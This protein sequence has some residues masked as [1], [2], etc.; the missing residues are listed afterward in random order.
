M[1][2]QRTLRQAVVTASL[3]VAFLCQGT[4]ALAGVTGN[5]Q[6]TVKDAS[7]AP[8]AGVQVQVV[9]PSESRSAT[10]DAG[11]HFIVLSLNPDTYTINLTRAGYQPTSQPGV[12]IFADQTQS[13]ALTMVKSLKTIARVTSQAGT[14]LVKSGVGA[15]LYSINAAQASAAAALGG[16]G[17]LNNAYSAMASVPGVQTSQGGIAW[18]FNGAYVRG[19][20]Y[21]YT[22]FEYDGIPI[23]RSFDNYNAST[24]SNL[25]LQELQVY[26]G[27]GPASITSSGTSGFINQVIKSGTFPGFATVN[28]GIGAPTFYHQ[29]QVEFGG[30]TPDRT[31]SYYVGLSGYNQQLRFFDSTNGAGYGVPGGIFSGNTGGFLIGYGALSNQILVTSPT[32]IEGIETG[33]GDKGMCPLVGQAFSAPSQGCWQYYSG[34]GGNPFQIA[35]RENVINLHLGVPKHNGLRDDVQLLW[36]GSAL[37]NYFDESP[38]DLGTSVNQFSYSAYGTH[39]AAP[40]C[41]PENIAPGLTVNGCHSPTGAAGQII[42]LAGLGSYFTCTAAGGP[43]CGP[44]YAGYAD[45]VAYNTPFGTPIATSPGNIKTPGVYMAPD[46]PSHDFQGPLPLFDNSLTTIRNDTGITKVQYTY[47]LSQSAYLRAYGY[48]FYSDWMQ[49]NPIYGATGQGVPTSGAAAQYD[50]FTHTSGGSL[51]FQDQLNDQNLISLDG[52]YST[53][54]VI[55][56]NNSA[57]FGPDSPIGYM[58]Q[59]NGTYTCYGEN[60]KGTKFGVPVP[61]LSSGYHDVASNSDV[62]LLAGR[63]SRPRGQPDGAIPGVRP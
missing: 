10:T 15:D 22:S 36:S 46:T 34:I 29:A 40:I 24:E 14:S 28:L 31:F 55:R 44:T 4:W 47:A 45:G 43:G 41:G 50:L 32:F 19:Q 39:Y 53:A 20:N 25:G 51:D 42:P 7:G 60:A 23:N 21:Y 26:T 12:T 16:G 17:N 11:G 33:Q 57:A 18:D 6:G 48:T 58:S 37:T 52:N 49:V 3:V 35:D 13:V 63:A 30:S 54:S 38:A 61:C 5:V 1:S 27:G 2:S 59:H 9:A 8:I 56:F 62:V